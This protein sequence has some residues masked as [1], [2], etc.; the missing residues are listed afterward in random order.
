MLI[1][2]HMGKGRQVKL[3]TVSSTVCFVDQTF[4]L[5]GHSNPRTLPGSKELNL[6]LSR[7]Y[8]T[9]KHIDPAT[10][11][12]IALPVAIFEN[13]M[14]NEGVSRLPNVQSTADLIIIAFYFLLRVGEY[15]QPT[16]GRPTCTTQFCLKDVT[17]WLHQTNG[18]HVRLPF[19]APVAEILLAKAVTL[20]LD[21]Q[22]NSERDSTLH[23][24]EVQG[25]LNPVAAVARAASLLCQYSARGHEGARP[26]F[27]HFQNPVGRSASNKP[28]KQRL[29]TIENRV[30]LHSR[31]WGLDSNLIKKLGR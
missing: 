16:S 31:L 6:A 24:D 28:S 29:Y 18:T 10:E 7:L 20:T 1:I 25:P 8:S 22:K 4:Q 2:D 23:H 11:S 15:T 13:I 27:G 26:S 3:G 12:Q 14:A 19:D 17:F 30:S 21:N 5:A 9:Y